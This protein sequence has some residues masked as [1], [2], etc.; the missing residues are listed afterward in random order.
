MRQR[1]ASRCG[2]D[3]VGS[4]RCAFSE[5]ATAPGELGFRRL[6]LP[7]NAYLFHQ[8]TAAASMYIL[9]KGAIRLVRHQFRGRTVDLGIRWPGDI[10]AVRV[11][12]EHAYSALAA[13]SSVVRVATG[14]VIRRLAERYPE[15][16]QRVAEQLALDGSRFVRRIAALASGRASDR[17]AGVLACLAEE[18]HGATEEVGTVPIGLSVQHIADMA[19]CSR[20]TAST[21]LH[22]KEKDGV[23]S[24]D[25]R[26]LVI[27]EP[28]RLYDPPNAAG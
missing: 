8:E 24:R 2:V 16:S 15:L 3:C 18:A 23:I 19:A 14:Q 21:W 17:L 9:C 4:T 1:S 13:R 10:L 12:Y 26:K 7:R 20:Q 28:S 22:R 25:R 5:I 27:A 6:A 11:P